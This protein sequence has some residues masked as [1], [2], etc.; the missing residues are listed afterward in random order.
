MTLLHS[1]W[2]DRHSFLWFNVFVWL[3]ST[4]FCLFISQ[5]SDVTTIRVIERLAIVLLSYHEYREKY[6]LLGDLK[7]SI[8]KFIYLFVYTCV[9][10]I[11]IVNTYFALADLYKIL[12]HYVALFVVSIHCSCCR[13]YS[14]LLRLNYISLFAS[15]IFDTVSHPMKTIRYY[16][17]NLH[18]YRAKKLLLS[19]SLPYS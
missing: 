10:S 2:L 4:F 9:V 15:K 17:A 3:I 7:K 12:F 11:I 6:S 16:C 8:L 5:F 1:R 14:S 18:I 19:W 13:F